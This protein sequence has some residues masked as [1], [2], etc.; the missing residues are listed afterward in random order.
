MQSLATNP[1][2]LQVDDHHLILRVIHFKNY[3]RSKSENLH[4]SIQNVY[5]KSITVVVLLSWLRGSYKQ[6]VQPPCNVRST[7][8]RISSPFAESLWSSQPY[9]TSKTSA[10][11]GSL[12]AF[13]EA[14]AEA[15]LRTE[16]LY[17]VGSIIIW[18]LCS[19]NNQ[20]SSYKM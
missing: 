3:V 12:S 8:P 7:V 9:F 10:P 5:Q 20:A 19:L 17:G 1:C 14:T 13:G 16:R 4:D 15:T 2:L 18:G 11:N 6:G